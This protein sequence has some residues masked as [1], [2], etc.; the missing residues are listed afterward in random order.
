MEVLA[1]DAVG[2]KALGTDV[3]NKA[4]AYPVPAWLFAFPLKGA[5]GPRQLFSV[6]QSAY[7]TDDMVGEAA[8]W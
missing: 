6:K 2:S 3:R 7:G 4:T 8:T 5:A 1:V